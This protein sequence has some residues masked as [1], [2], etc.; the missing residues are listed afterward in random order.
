MRMEYREW[1][2]IAMT[3]VPN[4]FTMFE[5][6]LSGLQISVEA[7]LLFFTRDFET[8]VTR[9]DDDNIVQVFRQVKIT[10]YEKYRKMIDVLSANYNPINNY[11]MT[12]TSTDTRTP[13]LTHEVTLNTTLQSTGSSTTTTTLNQ[14]KTTTDTPNNYTETATHAEN[15]YDNPGFTDA[16]KDTVVQ[17]GSRT[18]S[19][20]Y[21]GNPDST[22]V[23]SNGSSTNTGTNTQTET[24]T[25][26]TTHRLTRSG[27]IGVT[28]SQQMLESELLLAEKLNIFKV[29]E[30]DI[31]E[32]L[33]LQVWI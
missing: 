6:E 10:N 24:G 14:T 4:P 23:S 32:K 31:A 30:Q 19:E 27:N 2:E 20:S 33:F 16:S 22:A 12:E 3:I 15:P 28:T 21:S 13:N 9:Y 17:T 25:D 26:T 29:I 11:D 7:A 8:A 5:T 1:Q 18:V